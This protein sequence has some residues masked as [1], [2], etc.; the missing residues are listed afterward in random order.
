MVTLDSMMQ[1]VGK[2]DSDV[3]TTTTD[4]IAHNLLYSV[5]VIIPGVWYETEIA[6]VRTHTIRTL[7]LYVPVVI[8]EEGV[9]FLSRDDTTPLESLNACCRPEQ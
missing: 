8:E 1:S 7:Q 3:T 6:S 9:W 5:R 2:R 4:R